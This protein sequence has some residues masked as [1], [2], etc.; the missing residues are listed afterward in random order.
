MFHVQSLLHTY[1]S[2]IPHL[3][4][5]CSHGEYVHNKTATMH[6]TWS[7]IFFLQL[8]PLWKFTFG[9]MKRGAAFPIVIK[10]VMNWAISGKGQFTSTDSQVSQLT[11]RFCRK[12]QHPIACLWFYR[13][14]IHGKEAKNAQ[15]Y[16]IAEDIVHY[17]HIINGRV[18]SVL[19]QNRLSGVVKTAA[20]TAWQ[21]SC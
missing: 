2:Y 3:K 16:N 18:K 7:S 17:H 12:K 6:Y 15:S 13:L 5:Q 9:T 1:S 19:A 4:L 10:V 8:F 21:L 11:N 20:V 14:P